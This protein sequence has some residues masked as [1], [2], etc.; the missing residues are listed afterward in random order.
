MANRILVAL[1]GEARG[2]FRAKSTVF[3]TIAF[4]LLLILLFGA[5]FSNT[6]TGKVDLYVQDLSDSQ[7]SHSFLQ[8]SPQPTL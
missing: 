2:F 8:T 3:W 4:P 1:K 7:A 6:G 5:I